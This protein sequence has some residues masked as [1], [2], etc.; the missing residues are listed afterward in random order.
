M[1]KR[2]RNIIILLIALILAAGAYFLITA[3]TCEDGPAD[4]TVT[5]FSCNASD[6]HKIEYTYNGESIALTKEDDTWKYAGDN[7]FPLDAS[8]PEAMANAISGVDITSSIGTQSD[9][10]KYG[11][12]DAS[13]VI[14]AHYGSKQVTFS[15]GDE[16]PTT[17][18]TYITMSGDE[19]VYLTDSSITYAFSYGL[20]DLAAEG[21]V[22]T[23]M[24]ESSPLRLEITNSDGKYVMSTPI[25]D[26]TSYYKGYTWQAVLPD[27]TAIIADYGEISGA[28]SDIRGLDLT[29]LVA[30]NVDDAKLSELGFE[31][32]IKVDYTY[33]D[34]IYDEDGKPVDEVEETFSFRLVPSKESD[35]L[36]YLHIDGDSCVYNVSYYGLIELLQIDSSSLITDEVFVLD[37][38]SVDGMTIS[39]GGKSHEVT[40]D[41]RE[42]EDGE[43][44]ITAIIDGKRVGAVYVEGF[45]EDILALEKDSSADNSVNA[46]PD[47]KIVFHRNT[48]DDLSQMT[49][50]ITARD[51][52]F[53]QVSFAGR[54]DALI[55][56]RD[57][58]SLIESF[59]SVMDLVK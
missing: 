16:N 40:I 39:Y 44:E 32:A 20:L 21:E 38:D 5:L 43:E 52:N 42:N 11:L 58:Y 51:S 4:E 17:G 48:G 30:Y 19:S 9:L 54:S 13:T 7:S 8:H 49:L 50:T 22:P 36:Y 27:G 6:I 25:K 23:S 14:T 59:E 28:L 46:E 12:D 57:L 55:N 31:D 1:N 2:T 56:I 15:I 34:T 35:T 47:L 53:A 33:S 18:G 29:N 3:L 45:F 37:Y 26:V 10:S 41:R 24:I